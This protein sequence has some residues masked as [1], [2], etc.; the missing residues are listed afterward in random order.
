VK[1]GF[2]PDGRTIVSQSEN[3]T[4][5]LW[6]AESGEAKALAGSEQ[7]FDCCVDRSSGV[8]LVSASDSAAW[9][10]FSLDQPCE[11]LRSWTSPSGE[12]V[13]CLINGGRLSFV[14][15][16]RATRGTDT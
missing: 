6:D 7:E 5:H 10:P 3:G 15:L 9:I 13:S 16:I 14:E 1:V 12:S 11:D 4:T 8:R 2:S